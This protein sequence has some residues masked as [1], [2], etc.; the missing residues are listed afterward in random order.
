MK[1]F[2]EENHYKYIDIYSKTSDENG[3]I[4]E[5][6]IKDDIHLNNKVVGFVREFFRKELKNNL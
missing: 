1:G 5:K 3:F 2:C 4:L 6:Y